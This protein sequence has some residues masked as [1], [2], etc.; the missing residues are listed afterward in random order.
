VITGAGPGDFEK[1]FDARDNETR[2]FSPILACGIFACAAGCG[3][4][5]KLLAAPLTCRKLVQPETIG[6]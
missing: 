1:Q 2:P 5:G 4:Y 3:G 6:I